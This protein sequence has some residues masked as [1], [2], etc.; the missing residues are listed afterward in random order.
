MCELVFELFDL[1]FVVFFY[2]DWNVFGI[3]ERMH[4][5]SDSENLSYDKLYWNGYRESNLPGG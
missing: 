2:F 3:S 4:P 1:I 5:I